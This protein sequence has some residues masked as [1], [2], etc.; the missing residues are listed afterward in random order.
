MP[1][2]HIITD[3]RYEKGINKDVRASL[4]TPPGKKTIDVPPE[5]PALSA[6]NRSTPIGPEGISFLVLFLT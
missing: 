6:W 1:I 4:L 3:K 2:E 5:A